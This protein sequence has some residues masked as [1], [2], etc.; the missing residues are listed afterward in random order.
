MLYGTIKTTNTWYAHKCTQE[1]VGTGGNSKAN[2][3]AEEQ[4]TKDQRH[5]HLIGEQS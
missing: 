4:Y 1:Q 3:N 2:S 5:T